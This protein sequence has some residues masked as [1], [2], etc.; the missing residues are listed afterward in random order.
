M[1]SRICWK[2]KTLCILFLFVLTVIL[3]KV[4]FYKDSKRVPIASL[5]K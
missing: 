2:K 5:R 1:N 4:G 3:F